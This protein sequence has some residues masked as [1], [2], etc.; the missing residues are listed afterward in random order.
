[1][2]ETT[3]APAFAC[4][5]LRPT[6]RQRLKCSV[7]A[8]LVEPPIVFIAPTASHIAMLAATNPVRR[9][10]SHEFLDYQLGLGDVSDFNYVRSGAQAL[11]EQHVAPDPICVRQLWGARPPKRL[12][13]RVAAA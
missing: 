12:A 13:S 2:L 3:A 4:K 9:P 5:V 10:R 7:A 1:M 8:P 6:L 11:S